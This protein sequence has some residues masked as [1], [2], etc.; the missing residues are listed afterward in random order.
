M[1][2][3]QESAHCLNSDEKTHV[4][5]KM[6]ALLALA[7]EAVPDVTTVELESRG[8]ILICGRDEGAIEAGK[9]LKDDLDVT[10]LIAPPASIKPRPNDFP[11]AKGK[12]RTATG[13]LGAFEITVD[14]FALSRPS[15]RDVMEFE[16]A[17][18]KAPSGCVV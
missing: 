9:L 4:T 17:P 10:V 1:M 18:T 13:Y 11:V 15:S 16:P 6:A 7:A 5:P 14:E 12:I 8:V 2:N 3:P